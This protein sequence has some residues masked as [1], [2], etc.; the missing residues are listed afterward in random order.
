M[1]WPITRITLKPNHR[2]ALYPLQSGKYLHESGA[3]NAAKDKERALPSAGIFAPICRSQIYCYSEARRTS[4]IHTVPAIWLSNL[5]LTD[6][7]TLTRRRRVSLKVV[8]SACCSD[9]PEVP[10]RFSEDT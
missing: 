3:Q 6:R 4:S 2:P 1:L 10:T 8:N 5:P 7:T 9:Q